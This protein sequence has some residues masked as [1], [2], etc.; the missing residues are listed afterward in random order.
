MRNFKQAK[1]P[2]EDILNAIATW[3]LIYDKERDIYVKVAYATVVDNAETKEKR[4]VK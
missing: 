3:R 2:S 1:K 4:R